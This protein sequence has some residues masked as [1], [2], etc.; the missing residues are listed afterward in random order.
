MPTN[1]KVD[2]EEDTKHRKMDKM[3]VPDSVANGVTINEGNEKTK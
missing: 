3:V 2:E 1:Q